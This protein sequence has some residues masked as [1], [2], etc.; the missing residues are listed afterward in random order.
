VEHSWIILI[1]FVTTRP[2]SKSQTLVEISTSEE[3]LTQTECSTE[4]LN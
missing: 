1:I 4:D 2:L 3:A